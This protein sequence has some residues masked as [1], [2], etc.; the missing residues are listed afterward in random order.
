VPPAAYTRLHASGDTVRGPPGSAT[1]T[2]A[3]CP[4][5]ASA[6]L[7]NSN[8]GPGERLTAPVAVTSWLRA[9]ANPT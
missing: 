8:R 7:R 5:S 1:A 6:V 2:V 9:L 4:R 3:T